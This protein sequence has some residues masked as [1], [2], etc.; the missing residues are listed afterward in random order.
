MPFLGCGPTT[1]GDA[2]WQGVVRVGDGVLH[3]GK[4]VMGCES[5][6]KCS[7][8]VCLVRFVVRGRWYKALCKAV[9]GI[10]KKG[11]SGGPEQ[12][13]EQGCPSFTWQSHTQP[14]R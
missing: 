13:C 9:C 12:G 14:R 6:V 2:Q 5:L 8:G 1:A 11:K 3:N 10:C 7:D 4:A